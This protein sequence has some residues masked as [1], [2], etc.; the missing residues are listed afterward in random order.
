MPVAPAPKMAMAALLSKMSN[1]FERRGLEAVGPA[2]VADD[3]RRQH[4][5]REDLADE[6]D[7]EDLR[8]QLDVEER[9]RGHDRQADGHVD[10]GR[11]VD[12]RPGLDARRREVAHGPE[13]RAGEDEVAD[14]DEHARPEAHDRAEPT[15][16]EGVEA[17]CRGDAPAHLDVADGEDR[18]RDG[19]D[20]ERRRGG[21][22]AAE[23][24]DGHVEDHRREGRGARD[25]AEQDAREAQRV[26]AQVPGSGLGG[27]GSRCGGLIH[28]VR[29][30]VGA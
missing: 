12:A 1:G 13:H 25:D 5:Q 19:R 27:R 6:R 7:A 23:H 24:G 20:E 4:E 21:V 16:D 22:A 3:A 11:Q 29:P 8:G 10:P 26:R 28:G 14:G 9:Q 18:Q 30:P 15:G 17:A 2:A